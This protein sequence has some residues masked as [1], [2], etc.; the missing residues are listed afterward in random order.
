MNVVKD[1]EPD[2]ERLVH[3]AQ[4]HDDS[5]KRGQD[6]VVLLFFDNSTAFVQTNAGLVEMIVNEMTVLQ[7][8]MRLVRVSLFDSPI[9]DRNKNLLPEKDEQVEGLDIPG[10]R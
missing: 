8:Q 4:P 7:S 3:P 1:D 5:L 6:N 10:I 9:M 2:F